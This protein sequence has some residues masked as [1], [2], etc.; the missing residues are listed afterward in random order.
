M[1]RIILRLLTLPCLLYR[2]E[3]ELGPFSW[4]TTDPFGHPRNKTGIKTG[5][6]HTYRTKRN[7]AVL[8]Y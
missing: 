2:R 4:S 6:N 8:K 3:T 1:V 5:S 7:L